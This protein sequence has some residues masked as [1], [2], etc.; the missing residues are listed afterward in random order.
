VVHDAA[1]PRPSAGGVVEWSVQPVAMF[2][3]VCSFGRR[4]IGMGTW[5]VREKRNCA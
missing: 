4:Q 1:T 2:R 5:E 3:V